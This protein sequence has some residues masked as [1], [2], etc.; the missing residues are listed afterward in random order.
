MTIPGG[1]KFEP[2]YRD[3]D[4]FD[5]DWNEFNDISKVII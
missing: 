4:M 1:P 5:K 2:L 3:M